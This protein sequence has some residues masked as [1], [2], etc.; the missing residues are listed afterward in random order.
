MKQWRNLSDCTLPERASALWLDLRL[1]YRSRGRCVLTG[2]QRVLAM[3]GR[4][5]ERNVFKLSWS[6]LGAL[7]GVGTRLTASASSRFI[8]CRSRFLLVPYSERNVRAERGGG[9]GYD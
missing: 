6:G 9:S 5:A 2:G 1:K 3:L 4:V 7:F 8:S